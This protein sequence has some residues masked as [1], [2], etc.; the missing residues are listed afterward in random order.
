MNHFFFFDMRLWSLMFSRFLFE[1]AREN[2]R[3]T[4]KRACQCLCPQ[5]LD[6]A[7]PVKQR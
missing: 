6:P 7:L 1:R 3:A 5:C 2:E 4:R